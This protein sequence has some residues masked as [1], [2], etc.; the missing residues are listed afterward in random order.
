MKKYIVFL[1]LLFSTVFAFAVQSNYAHIDTFA[2]IDKNFLKQIINKEKGTY[3]IKIDKNADGEY[4]IDEDRAK[5]LF[6]QALDNWMTAVD[7]NIRR[8]DIQVEKLKDILDIVNNASFKQE[9]FKPSEKSNFETDA[10]LTIYFAIENPDP[11]YRACGGA[12][13]CYYHYGLMFVM[14]EPQFTDEYYI[15]V[16]SHELGHAFGLADQYS[17]AL[18][19]GS[20]IY[21]S[22]IRR[23]SIMD[24]STR[25]ITCDDADGFITVVD[26]ERGINTREFPSLCWDGI[27]IKNGRGRF[28]SGDNYYFND[29]LADFDAFVEVLDGD[30]A[31]NLFVVDITLKNFILSEAGLSVIRKMGFRVNDYDTLK[32][33][34]IKVHGSVS[35]EPLSLENKWYRKTPIG[36]WT[37]VLY[38][39]DGE[40]YKEKQMI[41]HEFFPEIPVKPM[42]TDLDTGETSYLSDD[43]IT[44][45]IDYNPAAGIGKKE[46]ILWEYENNF[47]S[48][49]KVKNAVK[50]IDEVTPR[51]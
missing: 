19:K 38:V 3:S 12:K 22:Q 35:E 2:K 43:I 47:N 49:D 48:L 23:P 32:N 17:G 42:F 8:D 14:V 33:V 46:D 5:R 21:N 40:E 44:P 29:N 1:S 37:F 25:Y 7:T 27:F 28:A 4:A 41:S 45:L 30:F 34:R 13:A 39:K 50:K 18:Y 36:L 11:K 26:R 51:Q 16:I 20:F 6:L 9:P 31:L 15:Q 24:S 10:T